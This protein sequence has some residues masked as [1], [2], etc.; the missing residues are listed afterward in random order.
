MKL[1]FINQPWT[2]AAPPKVSD[3]TGIWSYQTSLCLASYCQISYYGRQEKTASN[4]N[5]NHQS[6][7]EYRAIASKL[8]SFL[9]FPIA[10]ARK[11]GF[12]AKLLPYFSTTLYH[13]DYI[14]Q[15]AKDAAKRDYDLIHI[16]N[17]TQFVPIIRDCNPE[18][19]IVLH[20]HCEWINRM[21]PEAMASRLSGV[22][23]ILSCSDYI[24][25]KIKSRFPQYADICQTVNNGVDA[26]YFVPAVNSQPQ[27]SDAPQI[28]FVGRISPEKGVHDLIDAFIKVVRKHPCAILTIAGPHFVVGKEFL[29]DLQPEPEVQAL[30]DFYQID[31]LKYVKSKIPADL[32]S[33]VIFTGSLSQQ[34]LL[35][36]YQKANVVINPSLSEA[37]GMTL[38]EA[39]AT[40]TPVI[41]TKIGGM[42]EIV[43]DGV[44]GLLT[45]PGNPQALADTIVESISDPTRAKAM[46]KAGREKV[47][48]RYTW[49]KIAE[50]LIAHYAKIGVDLSSN[51]SE[52]TTTR[53]L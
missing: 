53:S 18:S 28:L 36:Y 27:D 47:L 38:V 19:K 3:S 24:T 41:A 9:R 34:E 1:S 51:V 39:M 44:T 23:L 7:I 40:E 15:I 12:Y 16:H 21:E 20:M 17:F 25:N 13:Y 43:D 14:R 37:F 29:F 52:T 49:S 50:S 45:E 30:K 48:Q 22:D 42:P 35:P 6:K 31:Y 4:S 2:I 10:G 32:S 11:L 33:Q 46:G 5:P 8:D 26:D